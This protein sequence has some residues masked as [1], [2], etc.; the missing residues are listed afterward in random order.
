MTMSPIHEDEVVYHEGYPRYSEAEM[1][2]RHR[3]LTGVM[4]EHDVDVVLANPPYHAQAGVARLFTE[5]SRRLLK[6]GGR[7]FLVTKLIDQVGEIVEEVFGPVTVME[8]R[9]Y[10]VLQARAPFSRGT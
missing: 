4:A 6:P 5:G 2:R 9:N 8:R 1:Q 3:W 10:H 7:F